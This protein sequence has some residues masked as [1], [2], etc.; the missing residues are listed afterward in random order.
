MSSFWGAIAFADV[1]LPAPLTWGV[2]KGL[3]LRNIRYWKTMP[4]AYNTDGTLTIGFCYPNHNMTENYN[5]PGSPYWCCKSF[6]TL[7]LPESHP[8]WATK[9]EPYPEA[10]RETVKFMYNPLHIASNLG[11]HTMI[12]SSGQQCS[13]PVKQGAAKYGKL[14]YSSAFGYS[15][16]VGNGTLEELGGDNTLALSDDRGETWKCRRDTREARIEDGKWLRSMWYP[17]PGV[18][19]E[20]WLIPPEQETLL[21]HVRVHRIK[22]NRSLSSAEGGFAIYG[23][24]KNSRALQ[25]STGE[26]FGTLE[27]GSEA[28][29][30]SRAGVSGIVDLGGSV[31]TGRALRMDAN[32]NLIVRFLFTAVS[33]ADYLNQYPRTV[34]PTLMHDM[35]PGEIWYLTGVFALPNSHDQ[36]GARAGWT[37]HWDKRPAVPKE[38]INLQQ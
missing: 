7:A 33:L 5:S 12:L 23:Q 15:V 36:E 34:L 32:T 30:A 9:E 10:L 35:Q 18:E 19:V 26:E 38:T 29:A 31:R 16:P 1:E 24:Q 14:A 13:Y 11:G 25:P 22:T 28:R 3:Q 27:K 4:G 8:F 6:I 2:V 21:W 37:A 17:W 20:T